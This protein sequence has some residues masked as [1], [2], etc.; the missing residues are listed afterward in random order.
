MKSFIDILLYSVGDKL[1][2]TSKL[3]WNRFE[4]F[5]TKQ[6]VPR[7]RH[8]GNISTFIYNRCSTLPVNKEIIF[9]IYK[10]CSTDDTN[11]ESNT[12][13]NAFTYAINTM[14]L[15]FNKAKKSRL[16]SFIYDYRPW[17]GRMVDFV[18]QLQWK[19]FL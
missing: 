5:H 4:H 12:I 6:T 2:L 18:G 9:K 7:L 11:W 17:T 14:S 8:V 1:L 3:N 10:F 16:N 13:T 19:Y 15:P